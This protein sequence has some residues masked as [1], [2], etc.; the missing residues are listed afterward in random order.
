M[1]NGTSSS[2]EEQSEVLRWR[3]RRTRSKNVPIGRMQANQ[4]QMP[5]TTIC[6]GMS[7][8]PACTRELF[9]RLPL[10]SLSIRQSIK[11]SMA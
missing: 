6:A 11:G 1:D 3:S 8:E 9:A 5:T 10:G 2:C 7:N 4:K